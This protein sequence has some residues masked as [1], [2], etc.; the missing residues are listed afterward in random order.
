MNFY[1]YIFHRNAR[2]DTR[3][4]FA[5]NRTGNSRVQIRETNADIGI[6]MYVSRRAK[7]SRE[8][9]AH[10][11]HGSVFA[12]HALIWSIIPNSA[13]TTGRSVLQLQLQ[14]REIARSLSSVL[15]FILPSIRLSTFFSAPA[16]KY[17]AV[18]YI[19][20]AAIY[21][22][23]PLKRKKDKKKISAWEMGNFAK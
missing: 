21:I 13:R 6:D 14:P 22:N 1:I 8:H 17:Y 4:F 12:L 16:R 20:M 23:M 9:T 10:G 3:S 15:S 2:T 19:S 5:S 18:V 11:C 7:R